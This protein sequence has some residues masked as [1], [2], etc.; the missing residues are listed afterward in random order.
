MNPDDAA[1]AT[2]IINMARA[3]NLKVIAEGVENEEQLRFFQA[4]HCYEIQG[5]YFSKPVAVSQIAGHL[6]AVSIQ[7]ASSFSVN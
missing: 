1:I 3:L 4:Q 6:R 2:A 7:P 5:F